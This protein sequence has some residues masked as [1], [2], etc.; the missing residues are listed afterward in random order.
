MNPDITIGWLLDIK[1]TNHSNEI[2]EMSRRASEVKM[3][4][5][6]LEKEESKWSKVEMKYESWEESDIMVM[7]G[8]EA[9][10]VMVEQS[11]TVLDSLLVNKYIGKLKLSV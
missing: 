8:H 9:V 5:E 3:I 6:C 11:M 4:E 2:I 1:I 7:T 10:L